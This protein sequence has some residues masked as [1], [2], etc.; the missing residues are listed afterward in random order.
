[1]RERRFSPGDVIFCEGEPSHEAYVLRSGRVEVVKKTPSGPL[2]LAVLGTGDVLGEMGLLDERPRS[3]SAVALDAVV[4]DAISSAEFVRI[5]VHEPSKSLKLLSA[6]FERVRTTNQM[7][8]AH[9]AASPQ[10]SPIPSA[11][12]IPMTPETRAA[13]PADG[14]EVSRFPFRVGRLPETLEAKTLSFN[15]IELADTEPYVLSLNHFALDLAPGGL[16]VR[17]RGSQYGTL[18]NGTHIGGAA[19]RDSAPLEPGEN[20]LVAGPPSANVPRRES[21]FRFLVILDSPSE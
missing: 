14:V 15:E 12:L 16:L 17:D 7:L 1:M 18:V 5:L 10:M 11:R 20:R 9:A 4:V 19:P 6:L 21:P 8:T 2:R 3:A 13:M